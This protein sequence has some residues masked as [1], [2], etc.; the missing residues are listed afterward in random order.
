MV[1]SAVY[2]DG[3]KQAG[4]RMEA[5]TDSTVSLTFKGKPALLGDGKPYYGLAGSE[6]CKKNND[7]SIAAIGGIYPGE[8]AKTTVNPNGT[9]RVDFETGSQLLLKPAG[10]LQGFS[11]VKPYGISMGPYTDNTV[12]GQILIGKE[13][14]DVIYMGQDKDRKI[15]ADI[16]SGKVK[17][18]NLEVTEDGKNGNGYKVTITTVNNDKVELSIGPKK[19]NGF[20]EIENIGFTSANF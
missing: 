5:Y 19:K 11:I 8:K 9:V 2:Q 20:R 1:S 4:V 7:G 13:S 18:T 10:E 14:I 15:L 3:K 12:A 17:I 16:A 6:V